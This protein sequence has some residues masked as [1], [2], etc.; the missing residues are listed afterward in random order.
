MNEIEKL[1]EQAI[2]E[3]NEWARQRAER[4]IA[5]DRGH[6]EDA[7]QV[8]LNEDW[9]KVPSD[10]VLL[11]I[12]EDA[13]TAW[14]EKQIRPGLQSVAEYLHEELLAYREEEPNAIEAKRQSTTT[15]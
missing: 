5:L 15:D 9:R 14:A 3:I 10:L 8:L 12:I 4:Q 1:A 2:H 7:V 11:T 13:Y 6:W